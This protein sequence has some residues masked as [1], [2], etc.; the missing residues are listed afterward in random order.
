MSHRSNRP[1][2]IRQIPLFLHSIRERWRS[3]TRRRA[4]SRAECRRGEWRRRDDEDA[5]GGWR[6]GVYA[7]L[8]VEYWMLD[9]GEWSWSTNGRS[10][11]DGVP[12]RCFFHLGIPIC[13]VKLFFS[14]SLFA[15]AVTGP[16]EIPVVVVETSGDGDAPER[17]RWERRASGGWSRAV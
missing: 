15:V 16:C 11:Q 1:P 12:R 4:R 7:V 5:A 2:Y 13:V 17:S 6:A 14:I 8:V 9:E 3:S 10:G